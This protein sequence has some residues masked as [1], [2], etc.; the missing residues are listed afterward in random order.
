MK[1][2]FCID[3]NGGLMFNDRR[4]SMDKCLID[5]IEKNEQ[6][7][8]VENRSEELFKGRDIDII[9]VK[10]FSEFLT[11]NDVVFFEGTTQKLYS[12]AKNTSTIILYRWNR[13]YPCDEKINLSE[14]LK[15]FHLVK[16]ESFKGN[17]HKKITKEIY[18]RECVNE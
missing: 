10:S 6:T 3:N 11:A 5:D 15:T 9:T 12:L 16:K 18:E 2:I 14:L 17:S 7:V 8:M 13:F 1:L 4:Q